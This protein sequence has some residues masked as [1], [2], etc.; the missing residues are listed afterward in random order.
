[1]SRTTMHYWHEADCSLQTTENW[2]NGTSLITTY[3][4]TQLPGLSY[5]MPQVPLQ[6]EEF[7]SQGY[8]VRPV[9]FGCNIS[10]SES[11]PLIIYMPN[12]PTPG[13]PEY[14]TNTTTF[15]LGEPSRRGLQEFR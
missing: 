1:M 12:A 4:R 11:Y 14:T 10:S 13:T 5:S 3:N 6:M 8:N 15:T 7:V 2:P 9:F